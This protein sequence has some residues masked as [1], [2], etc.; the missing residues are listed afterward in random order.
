MRSRYYNKRIEVWQTAIEA[1]GFGGN[2]VTESLLKTIWANV[3]TINANTSN[4]NT[5]LGLL[6]ASN[7][8]IVKTRVKNDLTWDL[9]LM[10]I[11]YR[12]EKYIIA[13]F[14]TDVDFRGDYVHFIATKESNKASGNDLNANL[15]V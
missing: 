4:I 1:D 15:N 2:V 11:K 10:F 8:I 7:S 6:D 9:Q 3:Q 5:Q 14:P 13:S 12:D